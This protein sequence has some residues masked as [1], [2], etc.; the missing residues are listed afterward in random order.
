MKF[1]NYET[2][3]IF[4]NFKKDKSV[5]KIIRNIFEQT[6]RFILQD[7]FLLYGNYLLVREKNDFKFDFKLF[8]FL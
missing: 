4:L 8:S 1:N 3:G 5:S 6:D 7:L 2:K